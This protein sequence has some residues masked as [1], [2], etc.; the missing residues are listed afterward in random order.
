[1]N[2]GGY[3]DNRWWHYGWDDKQSNEWTEPRFWNDPRF[4]AP[5]QPVVGISWYETMAFCAWLSDHL[6]YLITLPNEDQWE[7]AARGPE[8]SIYAWN[9]I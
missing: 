5:N 2:A 3:T 9:D 8:M 1:M 6:G 7:A 4:N